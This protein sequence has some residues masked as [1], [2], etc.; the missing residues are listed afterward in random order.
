MPD[1]TVSA[2][3]EGVYGG[4]LYLD[5]SPTG[6]K[7]EFDQLRLGGSMFFAPTCQAL[8]G[9]DHDFNAVGGF[10]QEFGATVRLTHLF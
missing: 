3:F 9:F 10:R 7:T 8:T 4:K 5:G 2:G 1:T 6:Q